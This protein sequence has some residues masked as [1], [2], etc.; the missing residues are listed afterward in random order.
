M[1][2]IPE[3]PAVHLPSSA[4]DAYALGWRH[5]WVSA[6]DKHHGTPCEQVRHTHELATARN[7]ALEEA[8][9]VAETEGV[10]PDLN[11]YAGGPDWYK[12]GKRIAAAIRAMK[13]GEEWL[14]YPK[15]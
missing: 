11:V 13:G 12:H 1:S 2:E 15:D 8:A 5:G 3:E 10:R 6:M 14:T 9:R 4:S 7:A